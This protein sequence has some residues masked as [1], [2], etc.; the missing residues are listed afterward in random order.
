MALTLPRLDYKRCSSRM[1]VTVETETYML[2]YL[3]RGSI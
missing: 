2:E 3:Y 1:G